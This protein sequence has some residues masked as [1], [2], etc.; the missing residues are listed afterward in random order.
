MVKAAHL[1]PTNQCLSLF[2]RPI[3]VCR[4]LPAG[5][6]GACVLAAKG[7]PNTGLAAKGVA[8]GPNTGRAAKGVARGPHTGRAAKGVRT[9]ERLADPEFLA[10]LLR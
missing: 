4:C 8:R 9:Q 7:M 6:C 10:S 3:N 2:V 1:C 5:S